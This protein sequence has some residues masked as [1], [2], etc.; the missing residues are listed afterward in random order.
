MSS[1]PLDAGVLLTSDYVLTYLREMPE[2]YPDID[3]DKYE[4]FEKDVAA[5]LKP[6]EFARDIKEAL[7]ADDYVW[8]RVCDAVDDVVRDHLNAIIKDYDFDALRDLPNYDD[9]KV[10]SNG[11]NVNIQFHELD[12]ASMKCLGFRRINDR[13]V[14]SQTVQISKYPNKKDRYPLEVSFNVSMPDDGELN[15][16]VLDED[17]CQPYDYQYM[18]SHG[19]VNNYT[20]QTRAFVEEQMERL[21][22]AGVLSGHN[23]GDYV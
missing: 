15:I 3:D 7:A 11:T 10:N 1:T 8:E 16:M 5:A 22:N 17:F 6:E 14:Y 20:K 9:V 4:I 13:W 12:E 19:T 23:P 18:E 2:M 21:Q